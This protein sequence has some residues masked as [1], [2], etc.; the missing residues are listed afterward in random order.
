MPKLL[1]QDNLVTPQQ[2]CEDA[3]KEN[4]KLGQNKK[5][6]LIAHKTHLCDA[7]G[8]ACL[9]T[10]KSVSDPCNYFIQD[11]FQVYHTRTFIGPFKTK[12]YD[13]LLNLYGHMGPSL[14]VIDLSTCNFVPTV[15]AQKYMQEQKKTLAQATSDGASY[16]GPHP[17]NARDEKDQ[18]KFKSGREEVRFEAMRESLLTNMPQLQ[19]EMS[20]KRIHCIDNGTRSL[21]GLSD[22]QEITYG[23]MTTKGIIG[24]RKL[25]DEQYVE[26]FGFDPFI[27]GSNN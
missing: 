2:I 8:K 15:N 26:Q 16:T 5:Y 21:P 7:G 11:N 6:A 27:K 10:L 9:S 13:Q 25:M 18:P 4:E 3:R 22:D 12:N 1:G 20:T 23:S 24:V 14:L 19:T 17:E